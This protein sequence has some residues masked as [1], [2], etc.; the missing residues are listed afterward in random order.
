MTQNPIAPL[1]KPL[2]ASTVAI[3]MTH[4]DTIK[5]DSIALINMTR[6]LKRILNNNTMQ[7]TDSYSLASCT[8]TLNDTDLHMIQTQIDACKQQLINL[9]N[10]DQI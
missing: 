5:L 6:N 2:Q 9:I 4:V 8:F 7:I 3:D 10:S 1:P